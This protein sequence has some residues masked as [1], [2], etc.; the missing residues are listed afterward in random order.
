M[1]HNWM[2]INLVMC[3]GI[4]F[5]LLLLDDWP[6]LN[7]QEVIWKKKQNDL[8]RMNVGAQSSSLLKLPS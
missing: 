7:F 6:L 4:T 5:F 8:E 2:N 1:H 3:N